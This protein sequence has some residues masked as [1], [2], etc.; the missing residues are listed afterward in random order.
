[1]K[2]HTSWINFQRSQNPQALTW[3]FLDKTNPN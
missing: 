2:Q 3:T 1:L